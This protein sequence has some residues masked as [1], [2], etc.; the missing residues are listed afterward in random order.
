MS[1]KRKDSAVSIRLRIEKEVLDRIDQLAGE[2][3]R[4]RFIHEAILEK[5]DEELPPIMFDLIRDVDDLKARVTFLESSKSVS[6]HLSELNDIAR[7]ELCIDEIDRKLLAYFIKNE[8]ATTPELA[9]NILG[10]R[11][12]RRTILDRIDRM[13]ER[14]KHL[15]GSAILRYQKGLVNNKRGA[16]WITNLEFVVI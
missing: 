2:R 14:A 10:S 9:E 7:N 6:M 5:L 13:N 12:K 4:Q 11:S 1:K 16:W 3:G 15:F 8:G